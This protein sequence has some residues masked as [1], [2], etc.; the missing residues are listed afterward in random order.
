M[1]Q[2]SNSPSTFQKPCI[3]ITFSLNG[4]YLHLDI[5]E[6]NDETK[7][8]KKKLEFKNVID[9]LISHSKNYL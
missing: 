5:L 2:G 3:G 7:T 9:I 6:E 8:W 4:L 1:L